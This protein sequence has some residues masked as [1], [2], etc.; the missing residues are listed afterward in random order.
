MSRT[1]EVL[2]DGKVLRP[3][4]APGLKANTRYRISIQDELPETTTSESAWEVLHRLAG[5]VE[6]PENW[7]EEHD[8]YIHGAPKRR[9]DHGPTEG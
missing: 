3:E 6:A 4:T 1:L 2:Y 5:T 9:T 7:A 8:H